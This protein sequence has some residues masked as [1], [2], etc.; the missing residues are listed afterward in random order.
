MG[1]M[2]QR[3][4]KHPARGWIAA[5]AHLTPIE[6]ARGFDEPKKESRQ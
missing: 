1:E 6:R 3:L 5:L 4:A 2:T